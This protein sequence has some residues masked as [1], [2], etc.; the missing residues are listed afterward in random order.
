MLSR[1]SNRDVEKSTLLLNGLWGLRER[2]RQ[3]TLRATDDKHRVPLEALGRVH[4]RQRHAVDG[5][6]VLRLSALHEMLDELA[7]RSAT[8]RVGVNV[9]SE[10]RERLQRVPAVA[11]GSA[12][13]GWLLRPPCVEQNGTHLL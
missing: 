5:G 12:L 9:V 1:A 10:L 6:C 13:R 4:R 2:N 7:H 11:H 3:E 8:A